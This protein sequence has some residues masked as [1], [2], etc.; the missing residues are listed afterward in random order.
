MESS[1]RVVIDLLGTDKAPQ[2][3]VEAVKEFLKIEEEPY[4]GTG[5]V[6]VGDSASLSL[7]PENARLEKVFAPKGV[8]MDVQP[9]FALRNLKDSTMAKGLSMLSEGRGQVFLSAGNTGAVL[10]FSLKHLKRLDGVERPGIIIALPE[11]LGNK[12]IIDAG[13][14]ADCKPEHLLGFAKLGI[15]AS[16]CLFDKPAPSVGLL[17]IGEEKSKGDRLR[18]ESYEVL[19]ELGKSFYGNVEPHQIFSS[20]VDVIVTD[21]FTGNVILKTLEGSFEFFSRYLKRTLQKG[22]PIQSIAAITL[23]PLIKKSFEKF[24]YQTYGAAMLAG[25]SHPVLIAHGRSDSTAMLSALKFAVKS[26]EV[27]KE[28]MK[29]F[30]L[31]N[32]ERK[33]SR[34][35]ER[36]TLFD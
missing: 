7:L 26:I 19:L 3:E 9:A 17:N 5:I 34:A 2:P 6:A 35:D 13:A 27:Q 20:S 8:P 30:S 22:N 24:R 28:I 16:K 33:D 12:I 31:A 32:P 29:Q 36:H 18:K 4:S 21:G 14:N 23:K 1:P 11:P 15:S 25:L 10:A